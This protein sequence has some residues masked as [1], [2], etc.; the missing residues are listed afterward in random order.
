MRRLKGVY[1]LPLYTH[2]VASSH[3]SH[4]P[5]IMLPP[6]VPFCLLYAAYCFCLLLLLLL[7]L[8]C[9]LQFCWVS[10]ILYIHSLIHIQSHTQTY[11]NR[12]NMP[13]CTRAILS[14]KTSSS[15]SS[16]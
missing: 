3:P 16:H 4:Q 7:V 2:V 5:I 1:V 6:Y 10:K 12:Q 11:T 8:Y 14:S 13:H 15:S 9:C